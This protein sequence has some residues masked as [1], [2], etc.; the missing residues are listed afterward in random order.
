M[1]SFLDSPLLYT[2]PHCPILVFF[3]I[4]RDDIRNILGSIEIKQ[5]YHNNPTG[6]IQIL[7]VDKKEMCIK[8]NYSNMMCMMEVPIQNMESIAN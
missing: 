5:I 2:V 8:S 1:S 7:N 4:Q 3:K 6:G